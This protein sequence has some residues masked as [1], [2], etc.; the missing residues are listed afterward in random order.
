MGIVKEPTIE[1][2]RENGLIIFEAISG[3]HAYGTNNE[4]S[5]TDIRGV[6]IAPQ[7]MVY[8]LGYVEQVND[9]KNDVVFYELGRF[10]KLLYDN[11]PNILELLNVPEDCIIYK[12]PLFDIVLEN[13][14]KFVTKKCGMSFGGYADS[15]IKKAKGLN[16]KQNWER[17]KI[18]RKTPFDFCYVLGYKLQRYSGFK[19]FIFQHVTFLRPKRYING[20]KI[21]QDSSSSIPLE[22]FMENMRIDKLFCGVA[23]V[24]HARDIYTLFYD[25]TA[26]KCFS[27]RIS[28]EDRDKVKRRLIYKQKPLGLGYHGLSK[29]TEDDSRVSN[30]LR[31]S[32]VPAGEKA[33]CHFYY[34]ESGYTRHCADYK[35]YQTWIEERNE[36]RYVET[37]THGQTIDGKNLMHCMRLLSMAEE[38]ARGQGIIVRRADKDYLLSIRRGEVSLEKLIEDAE[39]KIKEIDALFKEVD[40]PAEVDAE[41]IHELTVKIRKDFYANRTC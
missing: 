38:I 20:Y 21:N 32:S 16:K 27:D 39:V 17:D 4:N 5:D 37:K 24:T 19:R 6:F 28:L 29:E 7:E 15:Q 30:Q 11:N 10:L 14:E 33:L 9:K 22:T 3:S 23:A 40:L 25:W 8:G 12:S 35:A 2:L 36:A 41:L 31:M 1:Y 26:H 18:T 13:K 34:N